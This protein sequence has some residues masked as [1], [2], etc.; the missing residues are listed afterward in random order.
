MKVI[1]KEFRFVTGTRLLSEP[2]EIV[3]CTNN[4]GILSVKGKDEH[5]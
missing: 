3:N 4:V 2:D 1:I 5:Q